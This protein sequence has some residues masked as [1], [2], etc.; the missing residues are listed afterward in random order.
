VWRACVINC[1][2][3]T[4]LRAVCFRK[5]GLKLPVSCCCNS[6]VHCSTGPQQN[7]DDDYWA[8]CV[9]ACRV[10][11]VWRVTGYSYIR[12]PTFFEQGPRLEQIRPWECVAPCVDIGLYR[13]RFWVR[14]KWFERW[15]QERKCS[16]SIISLESGLGSIL[17]FDVLK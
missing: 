10:K 11:A 4:R 9:S 12:G 17:V 15:E 1:H 2:C 5:A 7:V 13:G 6:S 16:R 3:V 8:S 14:S